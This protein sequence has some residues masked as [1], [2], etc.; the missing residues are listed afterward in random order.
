MACFTFKD[1]NNTI[2]NLDNVLIVMSMQNIAQVELKIH[3]LALEQDA[4]LSIHQDQLFSKKTDL[5]DK[6]FEFVRKKFTLMEDV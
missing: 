2:Y 3:Q 6:T 4:T 1:P 5:L